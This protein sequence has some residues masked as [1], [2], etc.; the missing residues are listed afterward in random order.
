MNGFIESFL[1]SHHITSQ[2]ARERADILLPIANNLYSRG[3]RG[4]NHKATPTNCDWQR[5]FVFDASQ[6]KLEGSES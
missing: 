6:A 4:K 3:A 2:R 1:P 5:Y